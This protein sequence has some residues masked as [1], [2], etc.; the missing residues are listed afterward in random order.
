MDSK[1]PEMKKVQW[2]FDS[3]LRSRL[4]IEWSKAKNKKMHKCICVQ[5]ARSKR[6]RQEPMD[7]LERPLGT[8]PSYLIRPHTSDRSLDVWGYSTYGENVPSGHAC[9]SNTNES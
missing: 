4:R 8:R 3:V 6:G 1:V 2:T 9:R 7:F 5:T